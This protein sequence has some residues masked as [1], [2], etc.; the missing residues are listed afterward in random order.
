M[1]KRITILIVVLAL[2]AGGG[3]LFYK[4]YQ[5]EAATVA[6]L[7]Q[8]GKALKMY[9]NESKGGLYPPSEIVG[10]MFIMDTSVL[11]SAH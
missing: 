5:P 7:K 2:L 3:T 11:A 10:G 6:M 9:A 8:L 4:N 1:L